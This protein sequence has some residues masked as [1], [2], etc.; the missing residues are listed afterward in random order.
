MK[1]LEEKSVISWDFLHQLFTKLMN[2][3]KDLRGLKNR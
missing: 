2:E 3:I 1:I